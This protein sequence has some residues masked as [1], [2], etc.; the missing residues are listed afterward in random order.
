[1]MQDRNQQLSEWN[2]KQNR[3]NNMGSLA[4]L[5]GN[6]RTQLSDAIGNYYSN[7][8][9]QNNADLEVASDI[10]QGKA[11]MDMNRKS[12]IGSVLGGVGNFVSSFFG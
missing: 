3:I 4:G 8:A 2:T 6:D 1:M 12:G 7:L 11:N 10:A 5:Y 9:N